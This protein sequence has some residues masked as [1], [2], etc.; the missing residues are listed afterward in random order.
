[1]STPRLVFVAIV[2]SLALG[3]LS[4]LAQRLSEAP[5][6]SMSTSSPAIDP[7]VSAAVESFGAAMKNVSILAP[8]ADVQRAMEQYYA[9]YVAPDLLAQWEADPAHALGRS[10]SSPWPDRIVVD[11]E[12]EQTDG[13]YVVH[14]RVVEV[15]S[16][17][18]SSGGAAAAYPVS[19]QLSKINGDWMIADAVAGPNE[20]FSNATNIIGT[21][22]CLP[23]R[24]TSGPQT[25][26]CAY[27][28]ATADGAHYALDLS[29][30]KDGA[31]AFPTGQI[32]VR[33]II[34]PAEELNSSAWQKYD[35]A[36][37]MRVLDV[38]KN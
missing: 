27:G 21:F 26:E 11:D 36:G 34:T 2:L 8:A 13:S 15:T 9:P 6:S 7:G 33:A 14:G 25:D 28:L 23:H 16:A 10:V 32:M 38:E 18:A 5:L 29:L 20:D 19:L 31:V 1:M 35:I 22:G 3:V 37:I 12:A 4:F 24:I 30:L 17:E